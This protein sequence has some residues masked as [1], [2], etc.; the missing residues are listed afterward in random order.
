MAEP[1]RLISIAAVMF[2]ISLVPGPAAAYCLA[3]GLDVRRGFSVA[4]A[5]GVTLGKLT[6]LM[7]A[8]LGAFWV[9]RLHG[10][11]R[12][13][14]LLLA[15]AFMTL[16]ALRRWQ[17][18]D[19]TGWGDAPS[20]A[21]SRL[22][23]GFAISVLNP[24]SLATAVAVFPLFLRVEGSIGE[25]VTLMAA[26]LFGVFAAY[27]IYE[28]VAAVAARRLDSRS[29]GRVVGATYILAALGLAAIAVV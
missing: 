8:A 24:Q 29:Q 1:L 12:A 25:V 9:A 16:Q 20:D 21:R 17:R 14:M 3:A 26:A 4:A 2:G 28:V 6:H 19:D 18:E 11:I 22:L 7:V 15:A 23:Q 13:A 5:A 27:M 10:G